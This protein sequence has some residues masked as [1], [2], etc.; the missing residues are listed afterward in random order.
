MN[1]KLGERSKGK[2]EHFELRVINYEFKGFG[3]F[4]L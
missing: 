1:N 4:N 2:G 3:L